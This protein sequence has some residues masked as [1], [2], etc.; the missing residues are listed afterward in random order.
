MTDR[1]ASADGWK[2]S[3]AVISMQRAVGACKPCRQSWPWRC[4]ARGD[5]LVAAR[6]LTVDVDF[7]PRHSLRARHRPSGIHSPRHACTPSRPT[8]EGA[9][10]R[11]RPAPDTFKTSVGPAARLRSVLGRHARRGRQDP[12]QP[13]HASR[14]RT[15]RPMRSRCSRSG[16]TAW[17]ACGSPA[18]TAARATPTSRA[19]SRPAAGPRLHLGANAAEVL[20]EARVRGRGRRAARQAAL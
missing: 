7:S 20:G 5:H 17:T 10:P 3:P 16:T 1:R 14:S 6:Q 8:L 11:P 13:V 18:G 12:A 19:V 4:D 9:V 2:C 15:A